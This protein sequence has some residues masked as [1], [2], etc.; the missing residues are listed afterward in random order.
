MS[1]QITNYELAEM[2][3]KLLTDK[4]TIDEGGNPVE[5]NF[6]CRA[7]SAAEFYGHTPDE[8]AIP[9]EL[10]SLVSQDITPPR[11]KG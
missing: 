9:A 11:I 7:E 10:V 8:V 1:K 2:V 6:E 3:T 5:F 4:E